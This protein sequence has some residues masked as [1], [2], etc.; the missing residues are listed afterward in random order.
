MSN[1]FSAKYVAVALLIVAIVGA[2]LGYLNQHSSLFEP[3]NVITDF[4][5]NISTELA[6]I[7][8][9]V[10][11]IN[12]LNERRARQQEK[13]NLVL[14]I[15]SPVNTVGSRY[16]GRYNLK[17]DLWWAYEIMKLD[18]SDSEAMSQRYG[19]PIDTYLEG[20]RWARQNLRRV[21]QEFEADSQRRGVRGYSHQPAISVQGVERRERSLDSIYILSM[22]AVCAV[23]L[24]LLLE[25][26]QKVSRANWETRGRISTE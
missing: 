22:L 4:Y 23:V 21:H 9:T 20:Q 10:L 12:T 15:G 18:L 13:E 8:I 19:V 26:I 14:Q 17:G 3:D 11:V 6:S 1:R 7:A 16:D 2:A 5:A 25:I 24:R